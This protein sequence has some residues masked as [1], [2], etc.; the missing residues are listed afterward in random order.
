MIKHLFRRK[1]GAYY[2]RIV[3]GDL[4][5]EKSAH[6]KDKEVATKKLNDRY[7]QIER[8]AEG[9]ATPVKIKQANQLPLDSHLDRYLTQKDKEWTSENYYN[10]VRFRLRRLFRECNWSRIS[11]IRKTGFLEWRSQQST[12]VKTLNEFLSTLKGFMRWLNE[13]E[14]T[15]TNEIQS[16]PP[17]KSKGRKTF[18]RRAL[19]RDELSRLLASVNNDMRLAAYVTAIFTGLRRNELRLLEW[20]DVHLNEKKSLF[21]GSRIDNKK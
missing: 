4:R 17:L 9:L 21:I 16:I 5:E 7:R 3:Y 13:W 10:H 2:Y 15:D 20:G 14:L 19:T 6:T 18:E 1:N 11:D 12:C 8:E